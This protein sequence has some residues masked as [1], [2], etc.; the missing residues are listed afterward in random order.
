MSI[1]PIAKLTIN[2]E[3][4]FYD[5]VYNYLRPMIKL[6]QEQ[7][8]K[9]FISFISGEYIIKNKVMHLLSWDWDFYSAIAQTKK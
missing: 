8:E 9:S 1:V 4:V 7:E 5:F 2:P 3:K 6:G